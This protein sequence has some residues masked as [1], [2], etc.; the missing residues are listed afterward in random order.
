[1]FLAV[2]CLAIG[3]TGWVTLRRNFTS[4]S[5]DWDKMPTNLAQ[6]QASERPWMDLGCTLVAV[7][8]VGLVLLP[9][10]FGS[11]PLHR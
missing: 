2:F 11:K 5:Q 9:F 8:A 6:E 1:M 10:S 7:G 4:P 3:V